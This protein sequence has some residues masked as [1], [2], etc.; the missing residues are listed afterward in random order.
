MEKEFGRI[1]KTEWNDR[2]IK[3]SSRMRRKFERFHNSDGFSCEIPGW[4]LTDKNS[5]HA[6]IKNLFFKISNRGIHINPFDGNILIGKKCVIYKGYNGCIAQRCVI[7]DFWSGWIGQ[8][9]ESGK[10]MKPMGKSVH[11]GQVSRL[12]L[13]EDSII[14]VQGRHRSKLSFTRHLNV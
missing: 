9:T 1:A 7:L 14:H 5:W 2:K 8:A 4:S 10:W 13:V 6:C 12:R 11:G 3:R